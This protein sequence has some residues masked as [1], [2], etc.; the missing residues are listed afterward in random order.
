LELEFSFGVVCK[1][2]SRGGLQE[3][4]RNGSSKRERRHFSPQ[5]KVAIVKAHLV[6]GVAI[7]RLCDEHP[8]QPTPFPNEVGHLVRTMP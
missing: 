8:I 3:G 6:D 1:T 5:Q 2:S 7:S 4:S